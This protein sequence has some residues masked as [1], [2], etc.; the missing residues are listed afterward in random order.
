MPG[1]YIPGPEN[2]LNIDI[3]LTLTEEALD[4]INATTQIVK[5]LAKRVKD[6]ETVNDHPGTSFLSVQSA[7]PPRSPLQPVFHKPGTYCL[8]ALRLQHDKNL[9]LHDIV[10]QSDSL[11]STTATLLICRYC[12]LE[13]DT[14]LWDGIFSEEAQTAIVRQHVQACASLFD[15]KAMF[16][17][18]ACEK[19]DTDAEFRTA[20]EF[21]EHLEVHVVE[22]FCDLIPF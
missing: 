17:C 16:K 21:V 18:M 12:N 11:V 1:G 5:D 7:D 20:G 6:R 8:G 10:D 4:Q 13:L 19:E 22:P 15:R 2:I 9:T 3:I 14:S